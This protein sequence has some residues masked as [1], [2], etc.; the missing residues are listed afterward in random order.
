MSPEP[1]FAEKAP[2]ASAVPAY[3]STKLIAY[4]GNKRALLPFLLSVF[5]ELDGERAVS[6]FLDPFAGSG[7][8]SRLARSLGWAVMAND[9]EEYSRAVN[10]AW[11]GVSAEELPGLFAAEGG[12]VRVLEALNATHPERE[13]SAPPCEVEPYIARHYAPSDTASADWRRERLFYTREN[14]VFLDRTRC[15]IDALRPPLGPGSG[16]AAGAGCRAWIA[17]R[18]LLLGLVVYE[19]A[20]H[21]NTS[22]VFKAYH[23]G[24]GGHGRDALGRILSPMLLEAPLLWAGP[25]AELGRGDAAAFCAG[26]SADL[27]YLDPPYNQHQYGSNY[28]LLNTIARWDRPPVRDDRAEDGSLL[29]AAGIPPE[30]MER[31]SAFCSVR[32]AAA[33]FRELFDS[34]DART[35]VLSYNTEGLVPPQELFDLLSDRAE[36]R[37]RSLE[38]VKYRGGR[39]SA[40]RRPG[41][42]ELLFVARRRE[43]RARS[44]SAVAAAS[45]PVGAEL[46][47]LEA[48]LRLSRALAGPFDPERFREL[49]GGG[50]VLRFRAGEAGVEVRSYRCL[51][52]EGGS[53]GIRESLDVRGKKALAE[54]LEGVQLP[55]NRAACAAA[56]DLMEAGAS[57][58]R[59]QALAL[60]WLRKLAHRRYEAAF[61][62]LASRF[63]ALSASGRDG[64]SRMA[65]ELADIE[66]LFSMRMSELRRYTQVAKRPLP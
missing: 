29:Y 48:E 39:Q 35:V 17:E 36:V 9:S 12:L 65:A 42:S 6:S 15:A 22:G 64:L 50:E 18:A 40:S 63:A 25:P 16:T 53:D 5:S 21:A 30:W 2:A 7:S 51:V 20:T 66:A 57:D 45:A 14:A 3:A 52:L 32:T 31:R 19:A 37:I 13:N 62:A 61:R 47:A 27:C 58:R 59:L 49:S 26:R 33:A 56:L 44:T 55:D 4:L 11:L 54:L 10:E 34:I 46:A 28:H 24:F 43:G 60:G 23:K 41:N 8:V 1:T 38:Y